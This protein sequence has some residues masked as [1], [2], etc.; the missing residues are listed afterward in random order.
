MGW[1]EEEENRFAWTSSQSA[2][3]FMYSISFNCQRTPMTYVFPNYK[4]GH[5]MYSQIT[6]EG[7]VIFG[8]LLKFTK[9]G[10]GVQSYFSCLVL[11]C[12]SDA[13]P[14]GVRVGLRA[15]CVW[16]TYLA[17]ED[18][19]TQINDVTYIRPMASPWQSW[20]KPWCPSVDFFC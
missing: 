12:P 1:E 5:C 11:L 19:E 20:V 2:R 16:N 10:L 15:D 14:L 8:N 9:P 13:F 4:W 6:G 3:S 17:E 18:S 7:N